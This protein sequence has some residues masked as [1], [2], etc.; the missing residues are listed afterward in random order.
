M[1]GIFGFGKSNSP[2]RGKSPAK[3]EGTMDSGMSPGGFNGYEM[4]DNLKATI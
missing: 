1:S 2:Q 4:N 3:T